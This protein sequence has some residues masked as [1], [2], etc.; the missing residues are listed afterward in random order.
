[1]YDDDGNTLAKA[2][3]HEANVAA[4]AAKDAD[5]EETVD[6]YGSDSIYNKVYKDQSNEKPTPFGVYEGATC[7]AGFEPIMSSWQ[8]CKLAAVALNIT[9]DSIGHVDY[10][11]QKGSQA[12]GT[13][14]PRTTVCEH[15]EHCPALTTC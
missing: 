6:L 11:T 14:V 2:P 9:G 8:D 7:I 12:F 10:H 1:M 4:G 3:A 13:D 15:F 5:S